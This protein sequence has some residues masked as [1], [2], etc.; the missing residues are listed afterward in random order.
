MSPKIQ[1]LLADLK[2][3]L[4]DLYGTRLKAVYLFGSYARGDYNNN[5]DL[6]VMIVL[7]NYISYWDELVYSAELASNLSLEYNVTIS[8]MI[9]TEDQWKKG[10]LPIL[11]N[12]RAEG[13]PA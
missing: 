3:G 10:D 8:R 7:D 11:R 13:L 12:I 6:D 1:R 4:T 9:M 2:K 5:S